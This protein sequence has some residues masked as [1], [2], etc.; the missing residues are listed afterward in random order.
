VQV[1]EVYIVPRNPDPDPIDPVAGAPE[2]PITMF[3]SDITGG[4]D[5]DNGIV[6]HF[7]AEIYEYRLLR[8]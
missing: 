6:K 7:E 8:H 4:D 5:D 3:D 1:S 2:T